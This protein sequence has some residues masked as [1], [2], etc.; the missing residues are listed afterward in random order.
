MEL[1]RQAL[2]DGALPEVRGERP[3]VRVVVDLVALCAERGVA[4]LPFAG[5][6][7]AETAAGWPATPRWSGSSLVRAGY[8]WT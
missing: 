1:C 6:I 8:R 3:Q 7:T 4:E 2:P 5:P